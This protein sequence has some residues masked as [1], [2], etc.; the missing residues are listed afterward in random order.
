MAIDN[1]GLPKGFVVDE[2][3]KGFV[4]NGDSNVVNKML[5]SPLAPVA[6][7][8]GAVGL[9]AVA[10][11]MYREPWDTRNQLIKQAQAQQ[12]QLGISNKPV[13]TKVTEL[14]RQI[15]DKIK[16]L[17]STLKTMDE[18]LLK[19]PVN[20]VTEILQSQYHPFYN[21]AYKNYE[22][23]LNNLDELF[24]ESGGTLNTGNFTKDVIQPVID[25]YSYDMTNAQNASIVRK[26]EK[27]KGKTGVTGKGAVKDLEFS[28]AKQMV[29]SIKKDLPKDAQFK[30][31]ESWGDFL[32]KEAPE[33]LKV[34]YKDLQSSYK[35]IAESRTALLKHYDPKTGQFDKA[36]LSKYIS[37]YAKNKFDTGVKTL[38]DFLG[39]ESKLTKGMPGL[40]EAFSKLDKVKTENIKGILDDISSWGSK[41]AEAKD[42]V[43]KIKVAQNRVEG[44]SIGG[45]I[46]GVKILGTDLSKLVKKGLPVLGVVPQVLGAVDM[47]RQLQEYKDKGG[48]LVG[49]PISGMPKRIDPKDIEEMIK[50]GL[51]T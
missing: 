44:R 8:A 34:Q 41:E 2:L 18:T 17:N 14:P 12:A 13:P 25:K 3:P 23:T 1:T 11:K 45:K 40:K 22:G 20:N 48:F 6:M 16:S 5:S 7:G 33:E 50:Q 27:I 30:L 32:S 24:K 47:A 43:S 21:E 38:V 26:L 19:T 49:D 36:G 46:S 4:L 35:P 10:S 39:G 31:T 15:N 9:G 29:D 42:L 51:V 28:K 37:N